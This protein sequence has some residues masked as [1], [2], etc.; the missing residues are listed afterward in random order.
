MPPESRVS[1]RWPSISSTRAPP[2]ATLP[3]SPA[4]SRISPLLEKRFGAWTDTRAPEPP[5]PA[6]RSSERVITIVDKPGAPQSQIW[7]G[8]VGVS[9]GA[10]DIFPVRVMNYILGESFNS[11]LNGNLRSEHGYSYGVTSFYETHR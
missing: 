8:E 3:R 7:I 4:D 2:P 9:A 11:R 10:P 5:R 6:A 1:P